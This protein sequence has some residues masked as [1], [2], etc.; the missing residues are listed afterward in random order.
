MS[1]R[2]KVNVNYGQRQSRR[3][4]LISNQTKTHIEEWNMGRLGLIIKEKTMMESSLLTTNRKNPCVRASSKLNGI[5][6][7]YGNLINR[8]QSSITQLMMISFFLIFS[9][10]RDGLPL[11]RQRV[12]QRHLQP[13][14]YRNALPNRYENQFKKKKKNIQ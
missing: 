12:Q 10:L 3:Y 2:G 13:L 4:N 7:H 1:A 11:L 9:F 14:R 8:Q 6:E 5:M